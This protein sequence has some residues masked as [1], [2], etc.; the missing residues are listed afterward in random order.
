VP[1]TA[2]TGFLRVGD[3]VLPE[4]SVVGYESRCEC[5][6]AGK[7]WARVLEPEWEDVTQRLV[8]AVDASDDPPQFLR[9]ELSS[10]WLRHVRAADGTPTVAESPTPT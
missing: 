7:R 10:E 5:D 4:G 1:G 9:D 2:S 6:W 3:E 8:F